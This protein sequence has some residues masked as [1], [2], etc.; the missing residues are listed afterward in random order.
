MHRREHRNN[1]AKYRCDICNFDPKNE[2]ALAEHKKLHIGLSPLQCVVC[3][4]VFSHKRNIRPHMRLHVSVFLHCILFYALEFKLLNSESMN[5]GCRLVKRNTNAIDA[6]KSIIINH[7]FRCTWPI[8]MA[9]ELKIVHIA[10]D[11]LWR[12]PIWKNTYAS[13]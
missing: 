12:K 13:M 6:G 7:H 3:K 10:R 8:T 1:L 11:N 9:Y 2:E 4:K 5:S